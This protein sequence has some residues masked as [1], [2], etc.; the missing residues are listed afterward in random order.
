MAA[1]LMAWDFIVKL[2]W[3][4]PVTVTNFLRLPRVQPEALPAE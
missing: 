4:L 2:G 1:L 3:L